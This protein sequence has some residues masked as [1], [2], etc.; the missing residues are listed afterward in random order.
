MVNVKK[1]SE[2]FLFEK[3]LD[4]TKVGLIIRCLTIQLYM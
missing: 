2:L 4:N 1:G 3:A